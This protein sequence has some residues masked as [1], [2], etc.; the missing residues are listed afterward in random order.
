MGEEHKIERE[1]RFCPYC[2]EEIAETSFPYCQSCEVEV[3]HCPQCHE[4]LSRD[5]RECPHCGA[6][7][8]G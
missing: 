4:P 5:K 2:D 6:Q 3:F 8:K 7:I 1:K